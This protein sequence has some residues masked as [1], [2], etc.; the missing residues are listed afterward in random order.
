MKIIEKNIPKSNEIHPQKYL[1][2]EL[3]FHKSYK[4]ERKP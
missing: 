2:G 4:A 1:G 3:C